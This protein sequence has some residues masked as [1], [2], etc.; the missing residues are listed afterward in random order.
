MSHPGKLG[1]VHTGPLQFSLNGPWK[2]T[3]RHFKGNAH[4]K[5]AINGGGRLIAASEAC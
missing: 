5:V 4:L 1:R 2:P 3:V